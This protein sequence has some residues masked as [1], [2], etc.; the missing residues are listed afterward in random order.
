MN[1]LFLKRPKCLVLEEGSMDNL[2]F[3]LC[4]ES[5]QHPDLAFMVFYTTEQDTN[6][7]F[8]VTLS[9]NATENLYVISF[10]DD[11]HVTCDM[12][13]EP[14]TRDAFLKCAHAWVKKQSL[15]TKEWAPVLKHRPE[16]LSYKSF[17]YGDLEGYRYHLYHDAASSFER[18]PYLLEL[19]APQ[20]KPHPI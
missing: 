3:E 19:Y 6:P 4:S 2:R 12:R 11:Q 17:D 8:V 20:K 10:Y 13:F 7:R 9:T 16:I 18:F 15:E 5:P 1:S 14:L